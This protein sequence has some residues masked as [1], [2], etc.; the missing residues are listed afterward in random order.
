MCS[1]G[2]TL[3]TEAGAYLAGCA[4]GFGSFHFGHLIHLQL[5]ALYFLPLTFLFLHRV[6]AGRRV[7]DVVLLGVIAG[8]QAISSVYF[9][10]IGAIALAVGGLA[11]AV[12]VGRWRSPRG[13]AAAGVRGR[14]CRNP[15]PASCGALRHGCAA[16]R[17]RAQSVRG[18]SWCRVLGELSP[19]AAGQC[20]VRTH[21]SASGQ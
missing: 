2:P 6:I 1:C 19:G 15:R 5:Q 17:L 16:R 14:H 10:L 3:N 9:G 18:G 13:P 4:W 20:S 8:L 21:R 11:L 12:G 7:R